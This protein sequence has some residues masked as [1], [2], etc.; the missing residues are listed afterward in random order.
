MGPQRADGILC[1]YGGGKG[2][3]EL[4]RGGYEL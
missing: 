2:G 4:T 3:G 1:F